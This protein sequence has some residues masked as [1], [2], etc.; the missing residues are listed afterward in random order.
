MREERGKID[1]DLSLTDELLLRG[2]CTGKITVQSGGK[3]RLQGMC[4]GGLEVLEGGTAIIEGMCTCDVAN[5]GGQLEVYGNINGA[6]D[7][8]EGKT[9]VHPK[10]VIRSN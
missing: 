5:L 8:R 3:L 4:T 10:A 1:S 2:M 9:F 6:L 7:D